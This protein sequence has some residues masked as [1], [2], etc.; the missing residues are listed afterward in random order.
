MTLEQARAQVADWKAALPEGTDAS[1]YDVL[2][3]ILDALIGA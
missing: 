3:A 1:I 2:L